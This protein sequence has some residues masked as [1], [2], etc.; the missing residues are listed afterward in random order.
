MRFV[1]E[2]DIEIFTG[3]SSTSQVSFAHLFDVF[4]RFTLKDFAKAFIVQNDDFLDPSIS[5]HPLNAGAPIGDY[6][7][8]ADDQYL[9]LLVR[10]FEDLED[11]GPCCEGFSQPDIIGQKKAFGLDDSGHCWSL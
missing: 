7:K 5:A 9:R 3:R 4:A 8:V 2:N 1:K 11:T 6:A 10:A